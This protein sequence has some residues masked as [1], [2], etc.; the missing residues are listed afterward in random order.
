MKILSYG[1]IF[2]LS[3]EKTK[4]LLF[5]SWSLKKAVT[6][7]FIAAM[8]GELFGGVNVFDVFNLMGKKFPQSSAAET[9][10]EESA[11]PTDNASADQSAQHKEISAGLQEI[12]DSWN[13][14]IHDVAHPGIFQTLAI[15]F[16][17]IT[18]FVI[19]LFF[20]LSARFDFI[21]LHS[22]MTG[23]VSIRRPFREYQK[24]GNSLFGFILLFNLITGVVIGLLA[25][26]LIGVLTLQNIREWNF[27]MVF[28][29]AA[30]PAALAVLL[31]I[32]GSFFIFYVNHMVIPV[33]A[34]QRVKF[35]A[36]WRIVA[37]IYNSRRADMLMIP[38]VFLGIAIM[39][40]ILG[41][42]VMMLVWL[43]GLL[44]AA[45]VGGILYFLFYQ[46]LSVQYAGAAALVIL[47][48]GWF[49]VVFVASLLA[50]LP[51]FVFKR[52]FTLHF[53]SS[54]DCGIDP[55]RISATPAAASP[56]AP[57]STDV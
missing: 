17:V 15:V 47:G 24:E 3:F 21:W 32:A 4:E 45:I 12:K 39:A 26:W 8:A 34:L 13:K 25:A 52:Y 10:N 18:I 35:M 5:K 49:L 27:A 53:L 55:M 56:D 48:L 7:L 44:P 46:L 37:G 30:A 14:A 20:W 1:Q 22:L 50:I 2:Q 40:G 41:F 38:F 57:P 54:L 42:L 29:Q 6:L 43:A 23:E 36:A 16:G 31:I 11:I 51:L 19:I 9:V 33:M 28:A